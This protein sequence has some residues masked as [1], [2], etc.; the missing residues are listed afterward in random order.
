MS[1][2]NLYPHSKQQDTEIIRRQ[3]WNFGT[4]MQSDLNA[5]NL[6]DGAVSVLDNMRG[7]TN[8]L[9]GRHGTVPVTDVTLPYTYENLT[10]ERVEDQ[11][12]STTPIFLDN[13]IG[14]KIGT[15]DD[16][17]FFIQDVAEDFLSCIVTGKDTT[18]SE[19]L[20]DAKMRG[21]LNAHFIDNVTGFQYYL[22]GV[23]IYYRIGFSEFFGPYY[24][25]SEAK[26]YSSFSTFY[27]IGK[28]VCLS[29]QHGIFVFNDPVDG[30]Y[31]WKANDIMPIYKIDKSDSSQEGFAAPSAY[32]VSY[33]FTRMKG[34]YLD[35]RLTTGS[36][37]ECET[38]PYNVPYKDT[39]DLQ[40]TPPLLSR[41]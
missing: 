14:Y 6:S 35:N 19:T 13:T 31:A 16:R 29:N 39:D 32:N 11:I 38:P 21:P 27:K 34:K 26:P 37:I 10:L 12:T 33:T 20:T 28:Y 4:G 17:A 23:N 9:R 25:H 24:I 36:F 30:L 41:W 18:G 7:T 2:N 40:A 22:I 5:T 15:D 3:E 8:G 1:S